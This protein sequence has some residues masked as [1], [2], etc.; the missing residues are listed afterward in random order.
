MKQDHYIAHLLS[1]TLTKA[2]AVCNAA[3][4]KIHGYLAV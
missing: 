3:V 2:S 4:E 1:A